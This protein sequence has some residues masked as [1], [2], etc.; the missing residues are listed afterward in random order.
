MSDVL[1]KVQEAFKQSFD[2]DPKSVTENT[3]TADISA[4]DSVGHLSLVGNLESL[5][6]ISF[7]VDELMEMENVKQIIRIVEKKTSKNV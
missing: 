5:F 6:G 3:S 1:S 2:V 7:E 4:W